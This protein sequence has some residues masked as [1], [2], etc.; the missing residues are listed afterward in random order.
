[1]V[2]VPQDLK[3]SNTV[4]VH[5]SA[6]SSSNLHPRATISPTIPAKSPTLALPSKPVTSSNQPAIVQIHQPALVQIIKPVKVSTTEETISRSARM[7]SDT[8]RVGGVVITQ[9]TS[10]TDDSYVYMNGESSAQKA[11]SADA[12]FG[13]FVAAELMK[14]PE[15]HRKLIKQKIIQILYE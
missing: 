8:S 7:S 3:R 13:Q 6:V 2:T 1:M 5:V 12:L 10:D 14:M 11:A 4:Q 15:Q 9:S